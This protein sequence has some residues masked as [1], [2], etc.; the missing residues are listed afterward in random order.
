MGDSG[1]YP[2]VKLLIASV[3]ALKRGPEAELVAQYLKRT[4]WDVALKE[5]PD[6][7][8]ELPAAERKAREA[9]AISALRK[10]G[11]MLVALDAMGE[12]LTS[13]QFASMI[14]DASLRGCRQ[15]LFALGGHDGLDAAVLKDATRVVAFGKTTWPH[16]L[17]RVMLAEQLYRAYT[18]S[19]GHPYHMG[20]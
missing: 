15:L 5:I 8:A 10:E 1:P 9:K 4:R 6:A 11:S 12:Q 20:H 18:I 14:S 16:K 2:L 17:V 7:P 13:P 19:I 3:G